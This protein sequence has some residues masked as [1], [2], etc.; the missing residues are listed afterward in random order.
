MRKGIVSITVI[1]ILLV[2][3]L[4]ACASEQPVASQTP[5][6]DSVVSVQAE[7]ETNLDQND[8]AFVCPVTFQVEQDS[9]TGEYAIQE[10]QTKGFITS[11][12]KPI[13][14]FLPKEDVEITLQEDG[15]YLV[16]QSLQMYKSNEESATLSLAAQFTLNKETG[17][18]TSTVSPVEVQDT[19]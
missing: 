14:A 18:I 11:K 7:V 19:N 15:S 16:Q 5:G 12:G 2:A 8:F 17:E 13:Y 10:I 9:A 6:D 4:T 1:G 3:A